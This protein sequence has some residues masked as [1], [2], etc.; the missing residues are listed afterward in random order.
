MGAVPEQ[1][2]A[3]HIALRPHPGAM[4]FSCPSLL[5]LRSNQAIIPLNSAHKVTGVCHPCSSCAVGSR[6]SPDVR[7]GAAAPPALPSARGWLPF[8]L[9]QPICWGRSSFN[10]LEQAAPRSEWVLGTR[11]G[12]AAVPWAGLCWGTAQ[13]MQ[14]DAGPARRRDAASLLSPGW[15]RLPTSA[16]WRL[17]KCF[18]QYGIGTAEK[19]AYSGSVV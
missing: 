15:L 18:R 10:K 4:A 16:C 9:L 1:S 19:E 7:P 2:R 6:D 12:C 8:V 17:W 13:G 14:M 11:C 3:P 5:L